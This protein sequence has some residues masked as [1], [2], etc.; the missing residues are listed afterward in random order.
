LELN[1]TVTGNEQFS[2]FITLDKASSTRLFAIFKRN[3]TEHQLSCVSITAQRNDHGR[4]CW[5]KN[6]V[7]SVRK[8]ETVKSKTKKCELQGRQKGVHY[9]DT[10]PLIFQ[11][12]GNRAQM[13]LHD[14]I[15]S[16]SMI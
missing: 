10:C 4:N 16:N 7:S 1:T 5:I 14:S 9:G 6:E 8:C 13:S 3:S 12:E 15:I 2:L 11:K